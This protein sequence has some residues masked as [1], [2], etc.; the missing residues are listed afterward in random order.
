LDDGWLRFGASLALGLL[1]GL[2]RERH[3]AAIAGVRSMVAAYLHEPAREE[4]AAGLAAS[5]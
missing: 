3:P 1:I 2:E 5:A 4:P